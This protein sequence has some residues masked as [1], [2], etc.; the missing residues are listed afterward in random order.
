MERGDN[1]IQDAATAV[2]GAS[3][4]ANLAIAG[5]RADN[6]SKASLRLVNELAK[7]ICAGLG[8]PL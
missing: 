5:G 6:T 2:L 7:A 1:E 8:S 3:R 4:A